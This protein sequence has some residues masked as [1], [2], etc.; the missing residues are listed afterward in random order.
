MIGNS[1]MG[2]KSDIKYVCKL[3]RMLLIKVIHLPLDKYILSQLAK[4][5]SI[6][7]VTPSQMDLGLEEAP[8]RRT[9]YF[10]ENTDKSINIITTTHK[11]QL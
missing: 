10:K 5:H 9:R 11:N 6:F 8:N 1:N 2:R 4:R 7:S 3:D